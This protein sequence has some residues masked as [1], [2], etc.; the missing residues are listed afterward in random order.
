MKWVFTDGQQY[1]VSHGYSDL[2]LNERQTR[3]DQF[4]PE[5]LIIDHTNNTSSAG[6]VALYIILGVVVLAFISGS[7]I[8]IADK[9]RESSRWVLLRYLIWK[10]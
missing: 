8:R 5:M 2:A 6:S 10:P 3:M 4:S 1:L 7:L 9:K